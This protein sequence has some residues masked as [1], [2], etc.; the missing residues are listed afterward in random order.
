M[1]TGALIIAAA[2]AGCIA[3]GASIEKNEAELTLIT[4]YAKNIGL[5]FQVIDDLLDG[6]G[7]AAVLG[8]SDDSK[9]SEGLENSEATIEY[10][11]KLTLEALL[12]LEKLK[13]VNPRIN[14]KS[15]EIAAKYL[16]YRK[17]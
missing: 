14:I 2:R 4:E 6:G 16:L 9:D 17:Y 5:A 15:L 13:E 8:S 12:N 1:K 7:F 3:A 10:A 11:R